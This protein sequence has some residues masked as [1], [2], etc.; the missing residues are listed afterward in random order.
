MRYQKR[1]STDPEYTGLDVIRAAA[2]IVIIGM[3]FVALWSE[4]ASELCRILL[5]ILRD[6]L[7]HSD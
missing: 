3:C 7:T 5:A 2:F 6:A 1:C 4:T